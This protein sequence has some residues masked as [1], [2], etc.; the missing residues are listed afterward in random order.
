MNLVP[1]GTMS[2]VDGG[3]RLIRTSQAEP[4]EL[5]CAIERARSMRRLSGGGLRW[6]T[7][8]PSPRRHWPSRQ[9]WAARVRRERRRERCCDDAS[10]RALAA[11]HALQERGG[12]DQLARAREARGFANYV[13][14]QHRVHLVLSARAALTAGAGMQ[15]PQHRDRGDG[16]AGKLGRDVLGDGGKAEN[17]DVQHLAGSLRRFEILAAVIPQP[18]V[19]SSFGP[20][21]A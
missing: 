12:L 4:G 15:G 11:K 18:E 20:S 21:T 3:A 14:I 16:G 19:Q 7:D 10:G 17:V 13:L 1:S 9:W 2:G 8:F 6:L 5:S